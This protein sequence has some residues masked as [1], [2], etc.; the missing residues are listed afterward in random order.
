MSTQLNQRQSQ[1]SKQKSTAV[2]VGILL[3]VAAVLLVVNGVMK[4][5]LSKQQPLNEKLENT[6]TETVNGVE[7]DIVSGSRF[8]GDNFELFYSERTEDAPVVDIY[9]SKE[10]VEKKIVNGILALNNFPSFTK[11][12]RDDIVVSVANEADSGGTLERYDFINV[13]TEEVITTVNRGLSDATMT[14]MRSGKELGVVGL[15]IRGDCNDNWKVPESVSTVVLADVTLNDVSQNFLNERDLKCTSPGDFDTHDPLPLFEFRG[16]SNDLSTIYFSLVG[17]KKDSETKA[18]EENFVYDVATKEL[19]KGIVGDDLLSIEGRKDESRTVD[20]T[21][22]KTYRYDTYNIQVSYPPDWSTGV[23]TTFEEGALGLSSP[24]DAQDHFMYFGIQR[25]DLGRSDFG[26]PPEA[27][28]AP[29][30][31]V[32]GLNAFKDE[33]YVRNPDGP[34]TQSIWIKKDNYMYSLTFQ[35]FK[36]F[37]LPSKYTYEDIKPSQF[38]PEE[39]AMRDGFISTITFLK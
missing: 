27:L 28:N 22:W 20:T 14:M 37:N 32:A 35:V 10:G 12:S 11:T 19:R 15:L 2:L 24:K 31:V 6:N 38:T 36:N 23:S 25:Y 26:Y 17:D 16:I 8:V 30:I 9:L 3:G 18:W 7:D 29:N 33:G 34:S 39:L 1:N 13:Q 21:N 5:D 4:R